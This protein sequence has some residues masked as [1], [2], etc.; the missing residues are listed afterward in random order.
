MEFSPPR[1]AY[2]FIAKTLLDLFD[3]GE[4]CYTL[5][6]DEPDSEPLLNEVLHICG[7]FSI[8]SH[9]LP[10]RNPGLQAV[11]RYYYGML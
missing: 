8:N 9:E 3:F 5:Q 7:I 1:N 2:I 10:I 6:A 4:P 11:Y